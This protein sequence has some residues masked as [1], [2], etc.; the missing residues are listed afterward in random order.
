MDSDL[1]TVENG[2]S[3][4]CNIDELEAACLEEEQVECPLY[5][6]FS[7]GIYTREVHMPKGSFVIGHKHKKAHLNYFLKGKAKIVDYEGNV[8]IIEAPMM[9]VAQPGRKIFYALEDLVW[10]NLF[11]TD[12]TDI[13]K[14]EEMFVEKSEAYENKLGNLQMEEI[15]HS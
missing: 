2:V 4:R 10:Q 9:F 11:P 15:C 14:L 5:H 8:E 1:I 13:E 6:H 7:P 3:I 12:E